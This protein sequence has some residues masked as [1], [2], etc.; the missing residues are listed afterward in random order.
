MR[1]PATGEDPLSAEKPQVNASDEETGIL[2]ATDDGDSAYLCFAPFYAR[3]F[4][5]FVTSFV[6]DLDLGLGLDFDFL[7]GGVSSSLPDRRLCAVGRRPGPN[8]VYDHQEISSLARAG[9]EAS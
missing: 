6:L 9:A 4:P 8:D 7:T 1:R 2:T 3:S 5:G